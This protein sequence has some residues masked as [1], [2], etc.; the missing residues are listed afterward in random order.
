MND[1]RI[2]AGLSYTE[3]HEWVQ[4]DGEIVTLGVTDYAQS[5][6]G[7]IVF[8]ETPDVGEE[9]RANEAFG[10]IEAVKTVEDLVAPISGEV[11]ETNETLV[12][13]PEQVN[14]DPYGGGWM[15]RVRVE[16]ISAAEGLLTPDEYEELLGDE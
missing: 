1:S 12:D 5:E 14:A 9:I 3:S 2:P 7:D 6:L 15:I 16:D 4:V 11:V 10:T 13:H 8:V